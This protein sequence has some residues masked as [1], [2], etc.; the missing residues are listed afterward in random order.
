MSNLQ[1]TRSVERPQPSPVALAVL[2][3]ALGFMGGAPSLARAQGAAQAA[4]ATVADF[5]IP[6]GPLAPALRELASTANIILSFTA[7]QSDGKHTAGV[8]GRQSVASA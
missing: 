2:A 6:A 5:R 3:L 4:G 7:Q 1:R 8:S